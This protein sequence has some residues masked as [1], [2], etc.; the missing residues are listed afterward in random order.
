M[1][2]EYR[3]KPE[4]VDPFL[5]DAIVELNASGYKTLFS[6]AGHPGRPRQG[7]VEYSRGYIQF[8]G[9][10]PHRE[11]K[12]IL[13][14]HNIEEVK[15]YPEGGSVWFGSYVTFVPLGGSSSDKEWLISENT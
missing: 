15:F 8:A 14:G 9:K 10:Y 13:R 12:K 7:V 3:V 5:L 2:R 1:P 6:C 4:D 11:I